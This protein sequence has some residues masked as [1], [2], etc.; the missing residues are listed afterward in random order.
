[1]NSMAARAAVS[2]EFDR[3]PKIIVSCV[4][5]I[6]LEPSVY[7]QGKSG[8]VFESAMTYGVAKVKWRAVVR[9]AHANI[10]GNDNNMAFYFYFEE[11]SP[12]LSHA[13]FCGTKTPN[14]FTLL[15]FEEKKDSRETVFMK[16]NAFGASSGTDEK[17]N[18]G[19][20]TDSQSLN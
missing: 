17:P 14:E 18:T 20:A 15:K 1:M 3:F 2:I 8:G 4:W 19:F 13:S 10:K 5:M 11:A 6:M 12:G 16:A 7:S 9:G